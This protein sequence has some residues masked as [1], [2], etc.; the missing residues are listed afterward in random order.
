MLDIRDR[1]KK[2]IRFKLMLDIGLILIIACV[3]NYLLVRFIYQGILEKQNS[4][5][6]ELVAN[7][8]VKQAQLINENSHG[9]LNN[10]IEILGIDD[11]PSAM[12]EKLKQIEIFTSKFK[13][14]IILDVN[15]IGTG[16]YQNYYDL[17]DSGIVKN[18][19]NNK[20]ISFNIFE[21]EGIPYIVFG[22][23]VRD[24]FGEIRYILLGIEEVEVFFDQ[25]IA[26]SGGEICFVGNR[27]GDGFMSV[28]KKGT[29]NRIRMLRKDY[30]IQ[31]LFQ[32]N[33]IE[34]KDYNTE[35]ERGNRSIK[36]NYGKIEGTE[37]LLGVISSSNEIGAIM[38]D[39]QVAML[40]GMLIVIS[41]GMTIVYIITSSVVRRITNISNYIEENIE[42]EFGETLPE[43]LLKN[44]DEIGKLAKEIKRLQD[45]MDDMFAAIKESV[46][47]L[48]DR[49]DSMSNVEGQLKLHQERD[50]R[51]IENKLED[52]S[53]E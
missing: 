4:E 23:M 16:I 46:D 5:K 37:W 19:E 34:G 7:V 32:K 12:R 39:F 29:V 49:A 21:H 36:V 20:Q 26:V 27:S 6:T 18:F 51:V 38:K 45:V 1:R 35:T 14:I 53:R 52:I 31:Q 48:N 17:R 43:E 15:G 50:N 42:S 24:S 25:I 28:G 44:E 3:F 22:Q 40:I 8:A 9:L 41:A 2:S 10:I 47:Y 30:G 13:D 11:E 33:L